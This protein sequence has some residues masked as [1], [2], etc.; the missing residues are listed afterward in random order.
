MKHKKHAKSHRSKSATLL[1]GIVLFAAVAIAGGYMV[2]R[3]YFMEEEKYS[4]VDSQYKN[5]RSKVMIDRNSRIDS[6]VE[7]PITKNTRVNDFIAKKINEANATF[8]QDTKQTELGEGQSVQSISYQIYHNDNHYLSLVLSV[9]Q[10]IVGHTGNSE[11][12]FWTFDM[13]TGEAVTLQD[14]F[15]GSNDGLA[16]LMIATKAAVKKSIHSSGNVVDE[17]ILQNAVNQNSLTNFVATTQNEISFHF[18]QSEAAPASAGPIVIR[19]S[20]DNFQLFLQNDTA[21][22]LFDIAAVQAIEPIYPAPATASTTCLNKKCIALTFDDGPG[23]YTN[24]LLDTLEQNTAKATFFLIGEQVQKQS[25]TVKRIQKDG[26]EI[27]NHSWNHAVLT[28]LSLKETKEQLS[29][30][31]AA[32]EKITGSPVRLMRPPYSAVNKNVYR[33]LAEEK[34]TAIFWSVDTRDWADRNSTIVCNRAVAGASNGAIV[35]LHDIHRTTV[36]AVPCII[37]KLRNQ[38]YD[39]VTVSTLLGNDLASGKGYSRVKY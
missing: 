2:V 38:G 34:M 4:F 3:N 8:V 28:K 15:N 30:T 26:H 20:I 17:E 19:L 14:L 18:S 16:R 6:F 13:K 11:T 22:A 7:Y 27:G 24:K 32:I 5:V 33:A 1:L 12:E 39:F 31:N 9:K 10:D 37:S 21:R 25:T 35:I 36:D 29:K 23:K